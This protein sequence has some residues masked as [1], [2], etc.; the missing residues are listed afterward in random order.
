MA[1]TTS[2]IIWIRS[3]LASLRVFVKPPMYLFYDNQAALHIAKNPVFHERTKHLEID[4]HF[5]RE[6]LLSGDL[7]TNYLPSKQQPANIFTKALGKQ[8]FVYLQSK[9]GIV[10]PHTPT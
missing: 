4:Y 7:V 8:Q 2:E 10:N 3:F 6:C 9:L 5:V 1:D